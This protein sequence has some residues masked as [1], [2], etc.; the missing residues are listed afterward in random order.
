M[1]SVPILIGAAAGATGSV[2]TNMTARE[3]RN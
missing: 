1:T 3:E 2:A